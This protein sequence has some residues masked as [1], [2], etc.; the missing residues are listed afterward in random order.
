MSMA[1]RIKDRIDNHEKY[2][3]ILTKC[4]DKELAKK[5]ELV[6]IQSAL[7]EKAKNTASMELLELWYIQIVEARIYKAENNIPDEVSEMERVIAET[8]LNDAEEFQEEAKEESQ[9]E[10][11]EFQPVKRSRRKIRR[12]NNDNND[13]QLSLF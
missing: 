11:N 10:L 6:F 7:A 2:V 9:E 12:K 4:S 1:I 13:G 3:S 5:L 8:Y